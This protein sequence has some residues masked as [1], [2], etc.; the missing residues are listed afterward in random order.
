MYK[1]ICL[2]DGIVIAVM[3]VLNGKLTG[4]WGMY[5][6]TVIIHI[7]GTLFAL[8]ILLLKHKPLWPGERLPLWMFTGGVIGVLT[9][10][11]NN[12]AF[13]KISTAA[14]IALGLF[15]QTA[16]S[17]IIDAFG[18][19]GMKKQK[20]RLST[21]I[22]L[23]FCIAGIVSMLIGADSSATA[24]L[25]ISIISGVSLVASRLVNSHL[26]DHGSPML[27]SFI[28]HLTELPTAVI[29]LFLLGR[30]ELSA[31]TSI[32]SAPWWAYLGGILGVTVVILN[33]LAA[34]KVSAFQLAILIFVGQ[35]FTGLALDKLMQIDCSVQSLIG[36]ILVSAGIC[37][38]MLTENIQKNKSP[39]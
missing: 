20:L 31:L 21:V 34:P 7:V 12:A 15:G 24:A 29:V 9:T 28:N 14:I 27:S 8:A 6:A 36:G 22:C 26:A 23:L 16:S 17:V 38:N 1:L 30:S 2:L 18:L 3:I 39:Q 19:F 4:C 25:F 33:C 13:G 32:P 35:I 11:A 10:V 5:S 37:A